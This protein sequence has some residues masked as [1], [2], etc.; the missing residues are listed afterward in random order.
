MLR[1]AGCSCECMFGLFLNSQVL[2]IVR[3]G[4]VDLFL[5]KGAFYFFLNT[6]STIFSPSQLKNS[7]TQNGP[8]KKPKTT[9]LFWVAAS[10]KMGKMAMPAITRQIVRIK[11]KANVNGFIALKGVNIAILRIPRQILEMYK[12]KPVS[13]LRLR[14]TV[15]ALNLAFQA[16]FKA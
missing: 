13:V 12:R 7:T 6:F 10:P 5:M 11:A 2:A 8:K 1:A 14:L 3:S 4:S 15:C 9:S 16:L